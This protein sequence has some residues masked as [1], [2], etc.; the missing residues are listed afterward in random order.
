MSHDPVAYTFEADVHCPEC[1]KARF[2]ESYRVMNPNIGEPKH[3]KFSTYEKAEE[4]ADKHSFPIYG[5]F[6]A[7]DAEDNEGNP[8][9]AIFEW[10]ENQNEDG[11]YGQR[12]GS[13]T[14]TLCMSCGTTQ[15]RY[16]ALECWNCR[17]TLRLSAREARKHERTQA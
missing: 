5:P 8:V 2:G 1:T 15:S 12:C 13:C 3:L 16:N 11:T 17:S 14:R 6:I 7:E 4:F 9:G 10:D